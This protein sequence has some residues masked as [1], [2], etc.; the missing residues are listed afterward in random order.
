MR[1]HKAAL[2]GYNHLDLRKAAMAKDERTPPYL[3]FRSFMTALDHLAQAT[4]NVIT[5]EVF[6]DHSGLLQGQVISALKF[7]DLVDEHGIPKGDTLERLASQ[8]DIN[9]RRVNL[10][11]LLKISY[12]DIIKLD[13]P[14]V[15]PSQ[16]DTAFAKYGVSGDTKKKAKTFFVKA[17]KF[18]GLNLS[19]LLMRKGRAPLS[20]RKRSSTP[21]LPY[22]NPKEVRSRSDENGAPTTS[23]TI[24][25]KS[26]V[27]LTVTAI[28]NLLD[29]D[30]GDRELVFGI[31]DQLKSHN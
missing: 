30:G 24:R 20:S 17:A 12:A 3:P 13:L 19:P 6:P 31:M 22:S 21:H 14:R 26:G 15:T 16:L 11:P 2:I 10:R 28:G 5:K 27:I 7:F 8:R 23:K 29:L 18:A 9:Q 25:L 4:P 1:G